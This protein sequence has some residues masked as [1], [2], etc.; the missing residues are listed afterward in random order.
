[1]IQSRVAIAV[2]AERLKQASIAQVLED[3]TPPDFTIEQ[4]GIYEAERLSAMPAADFREFTL[5]AYGATRSAAAEDGEHIH[6]WRNQLPIWVGE[7]RLDHQATATDVQD[8]ANAIRRTPQYQQANLRDGIMLA[9]GFRPDAAQAAEE[10]AN[11]EEI[12]VNF[13]RLRQIAI[14]GANFRE[15]IVGRSTDKADYSE[16]LTFI[17]PPEVDVECR[18]NG[19]HSVTFDAGGSS[20]MNSDAEIINVQWDFDYNGVRFSATQGYSY[21][22][23]KGRNKK[24]RVMITHKF[25]SAGKFRVACRVQD[26]RGGEGMWTGEVEA[27]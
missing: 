3:D 14:D 6:G 19:G 13:V 2:T 15:R 20:V 18:A 17:Q 9:W 12:D 16:F 26:S 5:K 27:L 24:P 10:L 11:R 1:M 4:W 8:F 23:Q 7:P 22:Q 21:Q 25:P